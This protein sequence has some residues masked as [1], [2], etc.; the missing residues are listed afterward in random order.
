MTR[1]ASADR[2]I[3]PLTRLLSG[4]RSLLALERLVVLV[5]GPMMISAAI[6]S[7]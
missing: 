6:V 3:R 5:I 2:G 4:L 1:L 7:R